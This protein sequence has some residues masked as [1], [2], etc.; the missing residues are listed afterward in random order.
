MA[1]RFQFRLETLLRVRRLRERH[2]TRNVASA[3]AEIARIDGHS[4][5]TRREILSAHEGLRGAQSSEQPNAADLSRG[6]AWISHLQ[7][8]LLQNGHM[9]SQQEQQLAQAQAELSR[10]R[11]Q[12]RIVE[13]LRERRRETY[14]KDRE[15]REQTE[16]DD[17]ARQLLFAKQ[18]LE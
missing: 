9:R 11:T 2:A 14:V 18:E 4:A 10:A 1:A 15:R 8:V 16:Q 6:R 17:L 7:H 5:A 3:Q 12:T 13:K